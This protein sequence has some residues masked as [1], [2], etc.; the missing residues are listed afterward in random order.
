[1]WEDL[2]GQVA[3]I[4]S[5]LDV[6]L[7]AGRHSA[8]VEAATLDSMRSRARDTAPFGDTKIFKEPTAF[9]R[10]GGRRGWPALLSPDEISSV[11]Q[12]LELM[13]GREAAAWV[14]NGGTV[15]AG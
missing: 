7:D 13:V 2:S 6:S 15:E 5:I 12:R 3:R 10:H 11:A 4:A 9:F 14:L 1:M 8:I